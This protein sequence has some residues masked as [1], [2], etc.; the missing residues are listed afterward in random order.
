MSVN[1]T[2]LLITHQ[3]SVNDTE[4]LVIPNISE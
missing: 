2:E 4:L 1:D 3:I